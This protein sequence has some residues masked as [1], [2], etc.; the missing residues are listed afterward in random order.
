VH[1]EPPSDFR[2][3][4]EGVHCIKELR[5]NYVSRKRKREDDEEKIQD[6]KGEALNH[7]SKKAKNEDGEHM[8]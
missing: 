7:V 6:T 5:S 1:L 8:V 3:H 2:A 4:F